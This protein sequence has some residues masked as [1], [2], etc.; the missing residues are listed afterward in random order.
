MPRRV[1]PGETDWVW[2]LATRR[3]GGHGLE[4][5]EAGE[6]ASRGLPVIREGNPADAIPGEEEKRRGAARARVGGGR[7]GTRE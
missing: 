7:A 5:S 3:K 6:Q 1:H 4:Q 2:S